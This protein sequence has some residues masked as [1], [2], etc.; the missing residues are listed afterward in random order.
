MTTD[1]QFEL[2]FQSGNDGERIGYG[3]LI[4]VSARARR[5]SI[6]VYPDARVEVVVPPRARPREVEHFI[7][8]QREWI[9]SRRAIALSNRP[10]PQ[11]FPPA[12]VELRATNERWPLHVA[13]GSGPLRVAEAG[14][15]LR[16]TGAVSHARLRAAMRN[17]L[18]RM[19]RPRLAPRVAA[20][21]AVTGV[22]YSQ[23]SIRRQRSR[24]GSC[25]ARGTISLNC[26]LLFQRPEVIDYLIVHELMHVKHMNHSA[27]FWQA[28]ERHCADWRALDRELVQGWRH[29]PRWVFSEE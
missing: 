25:S 24:W 9:D 7:A 16:V 14:Q 12:A 19:A 1:H 8:A 26:C 15:I 10:E 29:V 22:H 17:W 6:R 3:P 18:L 23:V 4:R 28:V 2:A 21:A 11:P 20:L 13:G 5:L 27:R